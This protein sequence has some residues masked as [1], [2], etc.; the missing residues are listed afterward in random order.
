MDTGG[1]LFRIGCTGAAQG[2]PSRPRVSGGPLTLHDGDP[3][4]ERTR[5]GR[6]EELNTGG[7][8]VTYYLCLLK[9]LFKYFLF[10]P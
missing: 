6:R 10:I 7:A 1:Q 8:A 3:R 2:R 4:A 9:F 5:A